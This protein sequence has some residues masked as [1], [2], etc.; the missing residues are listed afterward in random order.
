MSDWFGSHSTAPT[1]NAGL[2]LEMPGPT[3]DRGVKLMAAVE[4]GSRL[5]KPSLLD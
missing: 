3:R 5:P 4:A 2:D 1:I